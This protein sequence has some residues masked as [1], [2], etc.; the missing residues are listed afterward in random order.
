MITVLI[1]LSFSFA[2]F[3][4]V[5]LFMR[6]NYFK[7]KIIS[8]KGVVNA[9]T[10]KITSWTNGYRDQNIN[11]IRSFSDD[12]LQDPWIKKATIKK[13]YPDTLQIE[14]YER[15]A[16]MKLKNKNKCYFYAFEGELIPAT[17]DDV[18][19]FDNTELNYD[20]LSA[21]AEIVKF[22]GESGFTQIELLPSH[23]VIVRKDHRL[24]GAYNFEI[25]KRN[26]KYYEGLVT[27]YKSVNYVDMRVN[28]KI[29]IDGVKNE[30]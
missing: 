19:V 16:V 26:F 18:K 9:D 8:I 2:M 14:V 10:Q 23:L 6:S 7:T 21:A 25:F 28:G 20:K 22:L 30:T 11:Y 12:I 24:L 15:K 29:Y 27:L 17:C 4:S 1:M 5:G 3:Y 13:I